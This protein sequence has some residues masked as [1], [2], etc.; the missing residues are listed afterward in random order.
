VWRLWI[1]RRVSLSEMESLSIDDVY[2]AN[3]ALDAYT[4][5]GEID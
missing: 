5:A 4:S 2:A 1:E 3:R